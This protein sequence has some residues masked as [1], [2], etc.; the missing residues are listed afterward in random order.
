MKRVNDLYSVNGTIEQ[1]KA[2]TKALRRLKKLG[3]KPYH[4]RPGFLRVSIKGV[5]F[6]LSALTFKWARTQSSGT[7]IWK[8]SLSVDSFIELAFAEVIRGR[9]WKK[10]KDAKEEAELNL[11]LGHECHRHNIKL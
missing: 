9:Q 5:Y 7:Y 4:S 8:N 3:K 11:C 10:D 2:A 6:E 1:C